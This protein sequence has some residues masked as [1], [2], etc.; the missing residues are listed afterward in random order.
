[1]IKGTT[2]LSFYI[3]FIQERGREP[4]REEFTINDRFSKSTYYRIKKDYKDYIGARLEEK[5]EGGDP[6]LTLQDDI[7]EGFIRF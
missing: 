3:Q 6:Y 4:T 5:E 7:E 1:M 2:A